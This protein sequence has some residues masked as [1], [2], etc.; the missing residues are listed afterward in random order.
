[1]ETSTDLPKPS[2]FGRSLYIYLSVLVSIPVFILIN[3]YINAI[4]VNDDETVSTAATVCF[5]FGIFAGRYLVQ[6]WAM[7]LTGI[8]IRLLIILSTIIAASIAW[9]FIHADFPLQG[10]VAIN[11]ILFWIP[12][13]I[14]SVAVGILIKILRAV[15]QNQLREA[16]VSAAKSSSEL[17]LLQSQL[18]PHFLFN[19]LN[20]LYGLSLTEHERLPPLL[21]KLSELL[22]YSVYETTGNYMPLKDEIAY[23]INYIEFEKLRI[24]DRLD[25]TLDIEK[26]T[27]SD[28]KIAPMLLIVFV[29]NAF[30]H[31]KNT[32]EDK[33]SVNMSLRTWGNRILF[34]V[35]NSYAEQKSDKV[36]GKDSGFG[37]A[38][39]RKRLE[40]LY[41]GEHELTI[42]NENQVFNVMLQ[43]KIR[44]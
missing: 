22:R 25:I 12:F 19:T 18:S 21:L 42:E 2:F 43:L 40:L 30:K 9:L 16:Q 10:R 3:G 41:P 26:I 1:M 23:L 24:G 39:V 14:V 32:A 29:E 11:L 27:G 31:A 17:H 5:L 15:A 37:L 6:F 35:K 7:K 44:K 33:L 28:I 8:P 38:S 36:S 4:G 13:A 34:S 20:N